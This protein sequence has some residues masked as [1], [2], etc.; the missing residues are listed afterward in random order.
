VFHV[1]SYGYRPGRSAIDAVR[2]ARQRCWRYD[3]VLDLDVKAYFAL[4]YDARLR[5]AMVPTRCG[6][7]MTANTMSDEAIPARAPWWPVLIAPVVAGIYY[8]SIKLPFAQSIVSVLGRIDF[9]DI[10]TP[11]WGSHWMYRATAEVIAVGVGTFVAAGLALGR[12]R[13]AAIVG[14]CTISLS[15]IFNLAITYL[16]WKYQDADTL[17]VLDPWFQYAIDAAMIFAAP[18]IGSFVAEAAKDMHRGTRDGFGGI[19]R[20]HFLWLW[21]AA[22][23]YAH[24][25]ITPVAHI[26]LRYDN[27]VASIIALLI[28][29]IPAAAI[30]VPGYYGMT[31]LAGHHGDTMHPA[32]RNLIGVLVLIFGFV[33]GLVV[34]F[35]WYWMFQKI[36][37]AI[38][39]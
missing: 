28:N 25:L 5:N 7:H 23:W 24:G 32:G 18:L 33:I 21:L 27:M 12:E 11:R 1:D 20:F 29:F 38:F 36:Y 4:G 17:V 2:Q 14:G 30:A 15:F 3:W 37:D 10:T 8:L 26:M 31:I 9:F 16:V 6:K 39:G 19:N 34:Q 22:F 13:T 35:G